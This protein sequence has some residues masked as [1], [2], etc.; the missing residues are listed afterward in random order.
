[1]IG[2]ENNNYTETNMLNHLPDIDKMVKTVGLPNVGIH[3]DYYHLHFCG[4][5]PDAVLPYSG[6][7]VHT[8]IA[9]VEKRGYVT[10]LEGELPYMEEYAKA[11]RTIGYEGGMSL[12]AMPDPAKDWENEA[13]ENLRVLRSVFG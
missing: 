8:H 12:E 7:I 4:D 2:I 6:R 11:L 3:C 5:A 9:K 10:D 1:M 13:R